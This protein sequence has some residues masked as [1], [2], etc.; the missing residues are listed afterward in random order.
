MELISEGLEYSSFSFGVAEISKSGTPI[1]TNRTHF[2]QLSPRNDRFLLTENT[3]GQNPGI[4][5]AHE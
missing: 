4:F 3:E 5:H 2:D 1:S